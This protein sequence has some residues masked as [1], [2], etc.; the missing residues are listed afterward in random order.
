MNKK[1]TV[2]P[3]LCI[4]FLVEQPTW[5]GDYIVEYKSWNHKPGLKEKKIGQSYELYGQTK[6]SY[7][8]KRSSS[9]DFS[10]EDKNTVFDTD[11][12][13]LE[14]LIQSDPFSMLGSR[15]FLKHGK[16]PLL[17]KFTQAL[18]NSFQLHAKSPTDNWDIKPE[19]WYYLEPGLLTFGV[20]ESANWDHYQKVCSKID[21]FMQDISQQIHNEFIHLDE[22]KSKAKQFIEEEHPIQFVN[23]HQVKKGEIIDL[24]GGG[25]HH[26]W[27]QNEEILPLGNVLYE[28]QLDK[29][30]D[31]TTIRSF[32]QGKIKSDGSVRKIHVD[33]YFYHVD[34]NP[35]QNSLEVACDQPVELM[36][37][38][39]GKVT[40]ILFNEHYGMQEIEVETRLSNEHTTT[41]DSFHHLFV[42]DGE[43]ELVCDRET[44]TISKGHSAFV[45]ANTGSYELK[46]KAKKKSK[47]IKSYC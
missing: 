26:S 35:E 36:A 7:S 11:H 41:T 34:R 40:K 20:K 32:D 44:L 42:T 18:G 29:H 33:D 28:I 4:P 2:K 10:H 27:E 19:S 15:V 23:L 21:T 38:E 5:G 16:Q 43:V 13:P 47:V 45:P 46:N 39:S 25:I 31:A 12:L 24:A 30:D 1:L 8:V 6:L 17:L 3:Y 37:N 9:F 22:G 14:A